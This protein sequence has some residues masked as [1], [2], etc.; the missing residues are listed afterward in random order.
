MIISGLKEGKRQCTASDA[1]FICSHDNYKTVERMN[2]SA[3]K[4][5]SKLSESM[6]KASQRII[7]EIC[8]S[9]FRYPGPDVIEKQNLHQL[10]EVEND[11]KEYRKS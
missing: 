11:Q 1:H 5:A 10:L 7:K 3:T 8:R 2:H 6:Q 4:I 9:M